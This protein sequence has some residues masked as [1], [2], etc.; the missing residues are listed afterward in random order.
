VL[1]EQFG[2]PQ[3][4][5]ALRLAQHLRQLRLV[6]AALFLA[7]LVRLTA[8]VW[9]L[10]V[11]FGLERVRR[12]DGGR[13]QQPDRLVTVAVGARDGSTV[14]RWLRA[15]QEVG[16]S[17]AQAVAADVVGEPQQGALR[18]VV[19]AYGSQR[20]SDVGVL[21]RVERDVGDR[22]DVDQVL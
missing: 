2:P 18:G 9:R 6:E 14:F 7:G 13:R 10:V 19:S 17:C 11:P 8:D 20:M 5:C 4:G 16:E 22:A 21:G 15:P 3:L 12:V 1:G